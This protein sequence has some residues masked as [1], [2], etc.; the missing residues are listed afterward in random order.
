MGSVLQ[1]QRTMLSYILLF[2][3]MAISVYGRTDTF[4]CGEHQYTVTANELIKWTD[5]TAY[6][7]ARNLV[8][9]EP[10]NKEEWTCVKKELMILYM[11]DKRRPRPAWHVWLGGYAD[12]DGLFH[13]DLEDQDLDTDNNCL[14]WKEISQPSA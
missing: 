3:S 10:Q 6:C 14:C 2:S 12:I 1:N 7:T 11:V 13:W 5:C 8:W 4:S 9:A